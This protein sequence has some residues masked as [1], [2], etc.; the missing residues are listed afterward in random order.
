MTQPRVSIGRQIGEKLVRV[1]IAVVG[2]LILRLILSALPMLKSPIIWMPPAPGPTTWNGQTPFNPDQMAQLQAAMAEAMRAALGG[3]LPTQ[4]SDFLIQSHMA[5]FPITIANAVVDT[6]I[7]IV[8]VLFGRDLALIFRAGYAKLPALGQILNLGLITTVVAMAYYS[9]Q[10]ILLPFLWPNSQDIYG[11]I[12]LV[13]ALAPLTGIVV[14]VSKNMDAITAAVMQT[15]GSVIAGPTATACASCGQ[16]MLTG[17]KFCPHC[18][19]AGNVAAPSAASGKR[20]C[21]GCGAEN[22]ATA[23]FCKGCGQSLAS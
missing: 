23:K 8:L 14:I 4:T 21:A 1:S 6:L 19:A 17:T 22:L 7:F 11:W 16:T 2:L 12:F 18:G 13:L 3:K 5:I 10:G 20:F 9:Y 15:G